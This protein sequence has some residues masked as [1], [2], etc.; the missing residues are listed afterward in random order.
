MVAFNRR[1]LSNFSIAAFTL[2]LAAMFMWQSLAKVSQA[3]QRT[4]VV[5]EWTATLRTL[6]KSHKLRPEEFE[7]IDFSLPG[8]PGYGDDPD[9][10]FF[11]PAG[12]F[13]AQ[14]MPQEEIDYWATAKNTRLVFNIRRHIADTSDDGF[15]RIGTTVDQ[16]VYFIPNVKD[17]CIE[18]TT[19]NNVDVM[20]GAPFK[21]KPDNHEIVDDGYYFNGCVR[22]KNR[23]RVY[24][25]YVLA[26]RYKQPQ[27]NNWGFF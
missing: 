2:I 3:Q 5:N 20:K 6:L 9:N 11:N 16:L 12:R 26:T 18:F 4:N 15:I 7:N 21:T 13:K 25:F 14:P 22:T 8:D 10:E 23:E 27:S 24:M 19:D 17:S 1:H